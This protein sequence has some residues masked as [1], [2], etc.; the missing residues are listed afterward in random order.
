MNVLWIHH[1]VAGN[2][3]AHEKIWTEYL[4]DAPRLMFHR[5]VQTAR[6][7]L[8]DKMVTQL[9][10][11]LEG[12]KVSDG[13]LGNAYSCLLDIHSVRGEFDEGL[14][15]LN[16]ALKGKISLAAIN[17]TA[18]VR[19]RDGLVQAGKAFPHKIPEKSNQQ[20]QIHEDTS[21]SSSSSSDDD[22]KK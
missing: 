6:E 10:K 18:L 20:Q 19:L 7:N 15:A 11:R 8:D 13:A 1:F 3:E 17:R 16:G 21:S 5:I 22:V 4:K 2:A 12:T 9:I 14:K